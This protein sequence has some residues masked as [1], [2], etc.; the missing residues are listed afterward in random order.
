[1]SRQAVRGPSPQQPGNNK[2]NVEICIRF[3]SPAVTY[4]S[5]HY[6]EVSIKRDAVYIYLT[7]SVNQSIWYL[8]CVA[9]FLWSVFFNE[10]HSMYVYYQIMHESRRKSIQPATH[11]ALSIH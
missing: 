10:D 4:T 2:Q 7:P 8:S 1:M 3:H 6:P 11:Q 5:I 9:L